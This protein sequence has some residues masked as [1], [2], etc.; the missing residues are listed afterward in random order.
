MCSTALESVS[1]ELVEENRLVI[2]LR[3]LSAANVRGLTNSV[4]PAVI[5]TSTAKPRWIRPR[6]SS[7]ALYAAMPPATPRTTECCFSASRRGA[8]T[9]VGFGR[10]FFHR[11]RESRNFVL[12]QAAPYLFHRNHR[13]FFG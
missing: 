4:A 11:G 2:T 8:C 7:A 10:W 12:H 13:R 6:Q 3:P 1:S 9:L 5:T